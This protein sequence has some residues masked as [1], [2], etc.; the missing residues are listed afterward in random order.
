MKR[1][2]IWILTILIFIF[3]TLSGC[4]WHDPLFQWQVNSIGTS[5]KKSYKEM[6]LP[7]GY[8]ID[9]KNNI[10]FYSFSGYC[11]NGSEI[12]WERTSNGS[13]M[14]NNN[15]IKTENMEDNKTYTQIKESLVFNHKAVSSKARSVIKTLLT[16]NVPCEI[17]ENIYKQYN[18]NKNIMLLYSD[19]DIEKQ[20][21]F[22]DNV[23]NV[24]ISFFKKIDG[25]K[26]SEIRLDY[27]I[28][29]YKYSI[30]FIDEPCVSDR[31][32]QESLKELFDSKNDCYV[33]E[34]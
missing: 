7:E 26:Y 15:E 28:G 5:F 25:M 1:K 2:K 6:T 11:I 33:T 4:D 20:N 14:F 18:K 19:E 24:V 21:V 17:K 31:D 16:K 8:Y 30:Y 32:S 29:E 12:F 13:I 34:E 10:D 9:I 3:Y 27:E 22:K 23:K